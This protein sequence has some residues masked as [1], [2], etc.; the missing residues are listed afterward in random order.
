MVEPM[1]IV[2][3]VVLH[4]GP[5]PGPLSVPSFDGKPP[6]TLDVSGKDS[7]MTEYVHDGE[8]LDHL[9]RPVY[10]PSPMFN[11]VFEDPDGAR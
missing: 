6:P 11:F 7:A 3:H 1:P 4:G 10:R 5:L 9:G 2:L 8:E